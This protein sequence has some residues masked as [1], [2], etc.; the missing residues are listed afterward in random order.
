MLAAMVSP[1]NPM[2]QPGRTGNVGVL[3]IVNAAQRTS[4]SVDPTG[5]RS[6][7]VN[8]RSACSSVRSSTL[9]LP[10]PVSVGLR[11]IETGVPNWR[12][13]RPGVLLRRISS[14]QKPTKLPLRRRHLYRCRS[15]TSD[16]RSTQSRS[17]RDVMW[18]AARSSR[19]LCPAVG[20]RQPRGRASSTE[21]DR[22]FIRLITNRTQDQS[23]TKTRG[24]GDHRVI[25][26]EDVGAVARL[27]VPP[28]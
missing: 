1:T 5:H 17:F 25:R 23:R 10:P 4:V 18:D 22:R 28:M 27:C 24:E 19:S 21:R 26:A 6:V 13:A 12:N 8:L 16:P 2:S 20:K 7:V 15:Q 11:T 9:R 14:M 3:R